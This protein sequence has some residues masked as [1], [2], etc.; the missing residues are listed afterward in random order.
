[1]KKQHRYRFSPIAAVARIGMRKLGWHNST[2]TE[3]H[4]IGCKTSTWTIADQGNLQ[5]VADALEAIE[6]T[7]KEMKRDQREIVGG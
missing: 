4:A 5:R 6:K 1:M 3:L 2:A 7:L